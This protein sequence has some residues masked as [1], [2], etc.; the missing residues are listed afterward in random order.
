MTNSNVNS[1]HH[2][3]H[4]IP[5]TSLSCNGKFVPLTTF[6]QSPYPCPQPLVTTNLISFS[7]RLVGNFWLLCFCF[8]LFSES[9][10]KWGCTVFVF[11]SLTYFIKHNIFEVHSCCLEW[12]DFLVCFFY[13]WIIFLCIYI[14][15]PQLLYPFICQWTLR[16]FSCLDCCT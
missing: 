11:L 4:Y 16:L 2:A 15:I 13:G 8:G 14:Y 3:V 12:Q 10:D 7:L 1:N 9:T 6:L 5:S